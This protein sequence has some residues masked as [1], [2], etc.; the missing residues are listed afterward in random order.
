MQ[1]PLNAITRGLPAWAGLL[2][3]IPNISPRLESVVESG[4]R[5][6]PDDPVLKTTLALL[7]GGDGC[8]R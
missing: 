2:S 1:D 4:A 8:D 6:R 3:A 5:L 7:V